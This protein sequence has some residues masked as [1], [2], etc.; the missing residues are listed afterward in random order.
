MPSPMVKNAASL[1]PVRNWQAKGTMGPHE[2]SH[3]PPRQGPDHPVA[4][5]KLCE[6]GITF[7]YGEQE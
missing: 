1:I 4:L 2:K 7:S 5:Q 6:T 3:P